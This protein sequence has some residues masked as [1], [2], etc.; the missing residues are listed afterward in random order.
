MNLV[1]DLC[2]KDVFKRMSNSGRGDGACHGRLIKLVIWFALLS[3][4]CISISFCADLARIWVRADSLIHHV[5]Y[6]EHSL[7]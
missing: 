1:Y 4:I 5:D 7:A 6:T 2:N 3:I